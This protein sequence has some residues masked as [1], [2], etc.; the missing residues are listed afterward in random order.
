ME[1]F[2]WLDY[3]VAYVLEF[4]ILL[5][6]IAIAVGLLALIIEINSIF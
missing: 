5:F 6:F 4:A 3:A 2:I 1:E